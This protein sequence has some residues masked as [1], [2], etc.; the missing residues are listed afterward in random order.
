MDSPDHPDEQPAA[1]LTRLVN[2]YQVSQALHVAATLGIADLLRAGPR[3]AEDLAT[4]T[5]T[6]EGALYRLLRALA[7]VGVFRE[8]AGR[9]FALTP[10]GDCLRSDAPEPVGPWATLIG[11]AYYWQA[12]GHLRHSVRTGENAFRALH[13]MDV[14]AYREGRP[15]A[16][17]VFDRAMTGNSR[18]VAEAVLAAYDFSRFACVVDVAGGQG[19]FL[20]AMLSRHPSM[21]GVLFDQPHVVAGVAEVLAGAGV[22]ERCRVVGGS[23]FDAVPEGG[24]AY[25]L[26]AILHDWEDEEATAILRTCRHAMGSAGTLLVVERVVGAPN[27]EAATKFSDL[28]MLVM[29]GGRERT[30]D[31]YAVLFSAAGVRLAGATPAGAGVNVIEGVPI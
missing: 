12:W 30:L 25:V 28:N 6:H 13:G 21:R 5:S 4:A 26:K 7:S 31:E 1:T 22:A 14:W 20:G 9:R 29:P 15:E 11:E 10:L 8:E 17:V 2:G 16:S 24:D 18:R 19:A 27:E 23:F 3:S